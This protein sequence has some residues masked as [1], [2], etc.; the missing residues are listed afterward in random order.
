VIGGMAVSCLMT[1][2]FVPILHS[3]TAHRQVGPV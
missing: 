3:V 2:L 1:L